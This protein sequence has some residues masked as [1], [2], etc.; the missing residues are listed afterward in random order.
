MVVRS[1]SGAP[2][3]RFEV[4]QQF[5]PQPQQQQQFQQNAQQWVGS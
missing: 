2:V 5:V 1:L 4:T 3:G